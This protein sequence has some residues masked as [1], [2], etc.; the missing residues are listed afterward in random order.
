M[1]TLWVDAHY[2][3]DKIGSSIGREKREMVGKMVMFVEEDYR[4]TEV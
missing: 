2:L 1:G 4:E 3:R